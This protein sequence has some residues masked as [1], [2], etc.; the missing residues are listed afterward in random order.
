MR[1]TYTST[2]WCGYRY[3]PIY[4]YVDTR[5]V[6]ERLLSPISAKPS[7]GGT[8][9]LVSADINPMSGKSRL[10]LEEIVNSAYP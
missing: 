1:L 2:I 6:I 3:V 10:I 7:L 8:M 5:M 4:Q 9:G